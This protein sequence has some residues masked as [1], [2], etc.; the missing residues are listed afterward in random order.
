MKVARNPCRSATSFT[1]YLRSAA[2]S[3]ASIGAEG[4]MLI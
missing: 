2:L 3:A 1:T 4:A